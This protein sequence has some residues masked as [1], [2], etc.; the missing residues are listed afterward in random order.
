MRVQA[1]IAVRPNEVLAN[2]ILA[3]KILANKGNLREAEQYTFYSE[4][5]NGAPELTPPKHTNRLKL[6]AQEGRIPAATPLT[7]RLRLVTAMLALVMILLPSVCRAHSLPIAAVSAV[8]P[9]HAPCHESL[10]A[11]PASPASNQKC[12]SVVHYPEAL[13]NSARLVPALSDAAGSLGNQFFCPSRP[14]D[15]SVYLAASLS[16]PPGPIPLR[17]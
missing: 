7:S 15:H 3:S 5:S 13:L 4:C 16:G 6:R 9:A 8:Q 10:P 17:I 12:C 1:T 2:R 14:P 11:T